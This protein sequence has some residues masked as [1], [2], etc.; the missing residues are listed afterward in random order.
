[1]FTGV[2]HH[3]GKVVKAEQHNG[4]GRRLCISA[5]PAVRDKLTVD[6]SIAVN[7]VCLTVV[8]TAA[9]SVTVEVMPETASLTTLGS[10]TQG[11]LVNLELPLRASDMVSGHCIMGHVDGVAAVTD[12]TPEGD[13][14]RVTIEPPAQLLPYI[15]QKGA[16]ALDGVSITV[17]EAGEQYCSV[18]LIPHTLERTTLGRRQVGEHIN[19]EVDMIARAVA[20]YIEMRGDR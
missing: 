14:R 4:D 20:R 9:E 7:G 11:E 10:V 19:I 18:A 8:N 6:E 15:P 5:P 13:S 16:V 17:A 3:Q 2:I 1:M 12:I